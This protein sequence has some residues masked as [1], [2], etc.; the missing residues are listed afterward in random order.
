VFIN[1]YQLVCGCL[2][3]PTLDQKALRVQQVC[4]AAGYPVNKVCRKI[5]ANN[6]NRWGVM[7]IRKA[8]EEVGGSPSRAIEL[9]EKRRSFRM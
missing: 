6:D 1:G 2:P 7:D 9:L 3:E 5:R 8:M 4:N